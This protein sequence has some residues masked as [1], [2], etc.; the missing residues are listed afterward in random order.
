MMAQTP[1]IIA[2]KARSKYELLDLGTVS[3][4]RLKVTKVIDTTRL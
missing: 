4:Q 1:Y 3:L 2:Y